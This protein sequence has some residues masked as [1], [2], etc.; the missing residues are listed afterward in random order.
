MTNRTDVNKIL[1]KLG[2]QNLRYEDGTVMRITGRMIR[3]IPVTDKHQE[4]NDDPNN[5][6]NLIIDTL[7]LKLKQQLS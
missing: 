7:K 6:L 3:A 4:N 1:K 2:Q 5:K